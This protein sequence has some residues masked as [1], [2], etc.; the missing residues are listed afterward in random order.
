[1]FFLLITW[2][3]ISFIYLSENG[4]SRTPGEQRE[5]IVKRRISVEYRFF[6][7]AFAA[8]G[9]M[10]GIF[11][12]ASRVAV[13]GAVLPALITLAA[14]YL[15]YL[16][17]REQKIIDRQIIPACLLAVIFNASAGAFYGASVRNIDRQNSRNWEKHMIEFKQIQFPINKKLL[18]EKMKRDNK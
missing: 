11:L 6:V 16:F 7:V 14:T 9:G 5:G 17:T 1:L 2:I 8:L 18:Q 12:G 15:A 10:V 13:V 3:F 4:D